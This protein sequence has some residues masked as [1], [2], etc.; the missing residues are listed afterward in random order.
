LQ[1]TEDPSLLVPAEQVWN[2]DGS[3]RRWLD[4]PQELLLTELGRASRMF[5]GLAPGLRTAHPSELALDADGAYRFLS[6]TAA[7]LDEAGFGVVL[8][9]WWDRRRKLRLALSAHSPVDG[10]VSKAGKFGRDQLVEFRWELAVG[11]DALTEDEIAVLAETKAAPLSPR[12]YPRG[13]VPRRDDSLGDPS[14]RLVNGS[15]NYEL[16]VREANT[17]RS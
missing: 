12:V 3:L 16:G 5:P 15:P 13:P 2:D 1:S 4:R 17:A 14:C 6:G 10:V 7:V 8:P 11:D 9:S